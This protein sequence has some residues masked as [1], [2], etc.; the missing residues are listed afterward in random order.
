MFDTCGNDSRCIDDRFADCDADA[1]RCAVGCR[2]CSGGTGP[3]GRCMF[4]WDCP[5]THQGVFGRCQPCSGP[6]C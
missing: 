6:F 2:V 5:G 3:G 1:R 4:D